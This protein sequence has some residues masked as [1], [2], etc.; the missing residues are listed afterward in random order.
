V[1][2]EKCI[3]VEKQP[4]VLRTLEVRGNGIVGEETDDDVYTVNREKNSLTLV[5]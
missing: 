4:G 3:L 5:E 2:V 1:G